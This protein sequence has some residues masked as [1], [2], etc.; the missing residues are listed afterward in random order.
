MDSLL[1]LGTDANR[2]GARCYA[3]SAK[4]FTLVS[5]SAL[6]VFGSNLQNQEKRRKKKGELCPQAKAPSRG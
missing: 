4:K 5:G 6:A 3:S 1:D 2:L